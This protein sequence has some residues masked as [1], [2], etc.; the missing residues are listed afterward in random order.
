MS[1]PDTDLILAMLFAQDGQKLAA[2]LAEL[3]PQR[4]QALLARGREHRF[5]PLLAHALRECGLWG[6]LPADVAQQLKM[7]GQH[8]TRR[9]LLAQRAMV[10]LHDILHENGIDH[11]FLKGAYLAQFAYPQPGLRPMRDIDV[12]IKPNDLPAAHDLLITLGYTSPA[13]VDGMVA[14][15]I[16]QAK[17][18]PGL[19]TPDGTVSVELH[20]HVDAPGGPLAGLDAFASP[21][22][23]PLAGRMLP[24][25]GLQDMLVHLCVHAHVDAP[26]G[27]LA[28]LD[29]FAS[30][31][32]RPLAGRML[33]FM[34]LQDMLVHLCVHA[35]S[36]HSFNNG[37]LVVSDI[38]YL[39][40]QPG[41]D[42]QAVAARAAELGVARPVALTLALSENCWPSRRNDLPTGEVA[43]PDTLVANARSMCMDPIE[44]SKNM[45]FLA[46]LAGQNSASSRLGAVFHKLLPPRQTLALEF[47]QARTPLQLMQFHLKRWGR[48]LHHRVPTLA[49][50]RKSQDFSQALQRNIALQNWLEGR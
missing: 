30:P 26:G 40:R 34:G 32:H 23:R 21:I 29:A 1:P 14:A 42:L 6:A 45:A 28:G 2:P 13:D 38:G 49:R 39:L 5:L 3:T 27:P 36:F 10:Q 25:M 24:F 50:S 31:I 33:P 41:L 19:R 17:H 18:L 20:A 35:A 7:A 22:H 43:V 8:H 48:I 37:P 16:A 11:V 9:A 15:F 12:V 46:D 44:Q 4:W 47:G